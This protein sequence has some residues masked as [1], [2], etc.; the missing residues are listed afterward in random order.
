MQGI[1]D[2][3][4]SESWRVG[5]DFFGKTVCLD[6]VHRK[7]PLREKCEKVIHVPAVLDDFTDA[8]SGLEI[9]GTCSGDENEQGVE[10]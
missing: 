4:V 8:R 10:L 7:H 9:S 1:Q 3:Q 6:V 2:R 5:K